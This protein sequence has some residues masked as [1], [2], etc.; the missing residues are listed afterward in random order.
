MQ[1]PAGMKEVSRKSLSI[2]LYTRER[3]ATEI[4]PSHGTFY[5]PRPLPFE[6]SPERALSLDDIKE[7][8]FA[9]RHR[10]RWIEYYQNLEL[11][12]SGQL[13][14]QGRYL[15]QILSD[16]KPPLSGPA[17]A[18]GK[19]QGLYPD[20]WALQDVAFTVNPT[21]TVTGF[22]IRGWIP[23]FF[24][25]PMTIDVSVNGVPA[26]QITAASGSF[27][28]RVEQNLEAEPVAISIHASGSYNSASEGKGNDERDLSFVLSEV[29][30]FTPRFRLAARCL[31]S[32]KYFC[33]ARSLARQADHPH[34]LPPKGG[35]ERPS[36][37]MCGPVPSAASRAPPR[38]Y[39]HAAI[40][41]SSRV[42]F[43]VRWATV[44]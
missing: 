44:I 7:T 9:L 36:A 43:V 1:L 2:Y 20:G 25:D 33:A 23:D 22:C 30:F 15:K 41:A 21:S 14:A 42:S 10:D 19:S 5:V 35:P 29:E 18:T 17:K 28:I 37:A 6:L 12:L 24:P 13:E 27:E 26:M 39:W 32:R 3:P 11:K 34:D 38:A 4:A 8:N 16:T 31:S 40:T